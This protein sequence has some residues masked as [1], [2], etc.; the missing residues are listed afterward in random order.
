VAGIVGALQATEAIKCILEFG[1]L[2]TDRLLTVD[3]SGMVFRCVTFS[4]RED[5]CLCG[6][7]PE[8]V[9]LQP[10]R[11][12]TAYCGCDCACRRGECRSQ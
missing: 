12:G 8:I 4:R 11:Y 5:C 10:E 7:A 6:S 9:D 1:D 2:L 3:V